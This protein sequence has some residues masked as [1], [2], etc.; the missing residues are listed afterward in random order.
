MESEVVENELADNRVEFGVLQRSTTENQS[1]W[2]FGRMFSTAKPIYHP[3]Q[4]F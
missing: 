1:Q 4:T 2:L 3:K